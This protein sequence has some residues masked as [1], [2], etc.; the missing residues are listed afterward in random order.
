[1]ERQHFLQ[2]SDRPLLLLSVF[3]ASLP[4]TLLPVF[5]SGYSFVPIILC[6]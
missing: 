5:L 3:N 2:F 1:M 6:M 4:F